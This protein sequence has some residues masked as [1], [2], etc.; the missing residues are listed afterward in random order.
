MA[1]DGGS[2]AGLDEGSHAEG[3][4]SEQPRDQPAT[5]LDLGLTRLVP[6]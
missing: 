6:A 4:L 5:V 2:D 3:A 1:S